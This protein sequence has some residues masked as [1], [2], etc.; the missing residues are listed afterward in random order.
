MLSIEKCKSILNRGE[1]NYNEHEVKLLR[2]TLYNLA[3]IDFLAYTLNNEKKSRN[4]H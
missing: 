4:L 1:R 2:E 3:E